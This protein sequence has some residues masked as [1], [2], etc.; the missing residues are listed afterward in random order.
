MLKTYLS[1]K[2]HRIRVTDKSLNYVGSITLDRRLMELAHIS[3]NEQVHVVNVANGHRWVTY[4]IPSDTPGAC[5]LN[6]GGARLGELG[7]VLIVMAYAIAEHAPTPSVVFMD[8]NNRP[9]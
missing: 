5:V 2:L 8:E 6:G 1:S 9:V 4:A 3:A 7:D